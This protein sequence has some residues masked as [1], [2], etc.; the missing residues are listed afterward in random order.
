MAEIFTDYYHLLPDPQSKEEPHK[1]VNH[2]L[3]NC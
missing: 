1:I 2:W 3:A